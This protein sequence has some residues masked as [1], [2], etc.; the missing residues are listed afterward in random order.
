MKRRW[1]RFAVLAT[2]FGLAAAPAL[3]YGG[4]RGGDSSSSLTGETLLTSE[5]PLNPGTLDVEGTCNL[6]GT[7]TFTFTATGEATGP[8][9]GPFTENGT[10]V[11]DLLGG[12]ATSFSATFSI[13]APAG[14]VTG[15]K[16]L[17]APTAFGLCGTAAFPTGGADSLDFEG[18]VSYTATIPGA[19]RGSS[20]DTGT[21]FVVVSD[22][23]IRD[24]PGFNGFLFSETFTSTASGGG[25]DHIRRHRGCDDDDDD[26]DD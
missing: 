8:F 4:H 18:S 23:E 19:R 12:V 21:S 16:T 26:D 17:Q 3:A 2:A 7:S 22:T 11:V 13:D 20:T 1:I 15:T 25:C 5:I 14:T 6:L 10:I 9:P 24:Q